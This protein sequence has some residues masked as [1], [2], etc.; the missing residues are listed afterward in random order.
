ML[1]T[2]WIGLFIGYPAK[3]VAAFMGMVKLPFTCQCLW[4]IYGKPE[5]SLDLAEQFRNTRIR[6][7]N[8]LLNCAD[9]TQCLA[10]LKTDQQL[11]LMTA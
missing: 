5:K 9:V 2:K 11:F 8:W 6:M 7:G 10:S 1:L 3:D 4:K